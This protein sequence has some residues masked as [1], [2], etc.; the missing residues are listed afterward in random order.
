M[1]RLVVVV[2]VTSYTKCIAKNM[3]LYLA[4]MCAHAVDKGVYITVPASMQTHAM[5][6]Y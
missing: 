5:I 1:L 3:V 6:Q 2:C 4:L